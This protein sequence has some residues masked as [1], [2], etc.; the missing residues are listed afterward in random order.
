MIDLIDHKAQALPP[1][2]PPGPHASPPANHQRSRPPCRPPSGTPSVY[3]EAL[4]QAF[5]VTKACGFPTDLSPC[6]STSLI[7]SLFSTR[8]PLPHASF[9]SSFLYLPSFTFLPSSHLHI[10]TFT[11]SPTHHHRLII[12][13]SLSPT[14][15]HAS[16]HGTHSEYQ[17]TINPQTARQ[18]QRQWQSGGRAR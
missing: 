15:D 4:R 12:T 17:V 13:D 1:A 14:Q 2:L 5:Q 10:I 16:K 8:L 3:S 9:T 6:C 18:W 11:S 7:N